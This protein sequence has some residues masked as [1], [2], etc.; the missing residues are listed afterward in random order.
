MAKPFLI[1][2]LPRS[3]TAWLAAVANTIPDA[4]CYHEPVLE[5]E[6]WRESLAVWRSNRCEFVGISDSGLGFHL[7][8]IIETFQPRILIVDRRAHEVEASGA[9]VGL[10]SVPGFFPLLIERMAP[11]RCHHLVKVVPFAG[12]SS[13][14]VVRSCLWHLMP[15]ASIDCDKI[16]LMQHLNVQTNMNRMRRIIDERRNDLPAMLGAD[17]LAALQGGVEV[18]I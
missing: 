17:V 14:A 15:G 11:F 3:R 16:G 12:L 10:A 7:A 13:V 4:I 1:T 18:C 6:G 8:E 5:A 9:A 2:G